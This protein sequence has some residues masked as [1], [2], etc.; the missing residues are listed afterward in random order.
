MEEVA[1]TLEQN[2]DRFTNVKALKELMHRHGL[3]MR[4][5]WILLTK[6]SHR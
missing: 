5:M 4:F 1:K 2:Y 6:L 3:N